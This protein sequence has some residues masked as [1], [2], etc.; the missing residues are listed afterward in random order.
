MTASAI[1]T[2]T[3]DEEDILSRTLVNLMVELEISPI[4]KLFE[5]SND[6]SVIDQFH[7]ED[8]FPPHQLPQIVPILYP[9]SDMEL[10]DPSF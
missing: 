5:S 1:L 3:K 6:E 7:D 10:K 4:L 9:H 8:Y 2:S